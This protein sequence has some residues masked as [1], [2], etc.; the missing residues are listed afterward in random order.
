VGDHDA[1]GLA[2]GRVLRGRRTRGLI[3]ERAVDIASAEGMAGLSL[4]RIAGELGISKSGVSGHFAD[5]TELQLAVIARAAHLYVERVAI[6]AW[7]TPPGLGRVRRFCELWLGFMSESVLAGRCFFLTAIV[8][9]DARPGPIRD[10][11][12]RLRTHWEQLFT[13]AVNETERLGEVSAGTDASQV[14]F[15][16]FAWV[17]A[18]VVDSQLLGDMTAFGRAGRSINNRLDALAI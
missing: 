9:F 13:G 12:A 14:F 15:E 18:A 6:P 5:Q 2:D 8:E 11:L 7:N 4:A 3:L 16:I 17:A 1:A 10:E